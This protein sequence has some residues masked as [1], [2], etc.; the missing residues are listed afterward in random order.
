MKSYLAFDLGASS[1][2]AILGGLENGRLVLKE[3]HRFKNYPSERNGSFFWDFDHL[4]AEIKTGIRKA[5]EAEKEIVSFSIDTWGVDFAVFRNG[6]LVRD[7]VCY[8]DPRN[9][10]GRLA[11]HNEVMS[12]KELYGLTG[13]QMMSFNTLFQLYE[14]KKEYPEDFGPDCR[15]FLMPDALHY[16]LT[17]AETSEYTIASTTA[18]LDPVKRV[19]HSELLRRA[20]IPEEVLPPVEMPAT[21]K[22][23]LK[24]EIAKELGVPRLAAVKVGSHDTASAVASTPAGKGGPWAYISSGT[25]ALLGAEIPEPVLTDAALKAHYTNE[26]GF[27]GKIRFLTNIMGTWLLQETRHTWQEAGKDLG[28][29][30]MSAMAAAEPDKGLRFPPNDPS[31]LAPGDMPSRIRE[32]FRKNGKPVPETDGELLRCIYDSLADCFRDSIRNLQDLLHVKFQ[33]LHI[34]GGAIRDEFLMKRTAE[35]TGLPV[36]TGPL[37]ATATGNI[38]AQ[39]IASGDLKDNEEAREL[40]TRS[41]ELKDY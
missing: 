15:F 27:N 14:H 31:F 6:K 40:V 8:R 39:M 41:V 17:G 11:F 38:L 35:T 4:L 26:G 19:W 20:G 2:R 34:L 30:E 18:M 36:R 1:G 37:E 12:E 10:E 9:E 33:V 13:I 22:H 7:P 16:A 5:C 21:S 25:W 23:L 24:E 28:F 32:W 3:V 29:S